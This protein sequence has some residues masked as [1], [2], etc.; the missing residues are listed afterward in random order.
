MENSPRRDGYKVYLPGGIPVLRA[1]VEELL[2]SNWDDLFR[3]RA[4]EIS[5]A[6]E[7]SF[8]AAGQDELAS[9]TRS[10]TQLLDIEP[11][12]AVMLGK[13]LGNKLDELLGRLESSLRTQGEIQTG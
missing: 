4:R 3:Q 13:H 11:R 1:A 7:G 8:R 2:R 10:V 5:C 9:I 12:E 6:F